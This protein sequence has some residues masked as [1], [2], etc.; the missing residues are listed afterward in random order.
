MTAAPTSSSRR[1]APRRRA[2]S[3]AGPYALSLVVLATTPLWLREIGLYQ[4]LAL[5]IVIWMLFAL[6]YNLLLGQAGLPSFGHGAF[7]GV[8]AYAFGLAQSS[9]SAPNLWLGLGARR[10]RRRRSP[11][12]WWPR[13]S[14]TGA[15]STTRC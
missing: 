11:A 12:R 7:F 2:P 9:T 6:G 8:G 4:Y 15:A 14:R 10:W 3:F 5:E 1:H 13:S